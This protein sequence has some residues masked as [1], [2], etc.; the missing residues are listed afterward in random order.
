ML[1]LSPDQRKRKKR[2]LDNTEEVLGRSLKNG[3]AELLAAV[4]AASPAS[5]S[6]PIA[7]ILELAFR[8]PEDWFRGSLDSTSAQPQTD[9]KSTKDRAPPQQHFVVCRAPV[10]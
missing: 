10:P 2:R 3:Q 9:S 6:G 5:I 4:L 7:I 1:R 8:R